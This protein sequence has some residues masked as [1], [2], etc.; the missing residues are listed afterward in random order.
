MTNK[1]KGYIC[2]KM[3]VYSLILCYFVWV[4]PDESGF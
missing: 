1:L 2:V 4:A 3:K